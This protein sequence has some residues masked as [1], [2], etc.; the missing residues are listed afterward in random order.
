MASQLLEKCTKKY[1][2]LDR[3]YSCTKILFI[4]LLENKICKSASV[5]QQNTLHKNNLHAIMKFPSYFLSKF[6]SFNFSKIT[7]GI[8]LGRE[9]PSVPFVQNNRESAIRFS[10]VYLVA[11][12]KGT[13]GAGRKISTPSLK[14]V[15]QRPFQSLFPS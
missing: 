8:P 9:S 10:L 12:M 1:S 7:L 15:P 5:H 13:A 2:G 4:A 11:S 6:C 3:K 14:I